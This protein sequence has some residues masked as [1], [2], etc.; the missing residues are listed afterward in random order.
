[1]TLSLA[2]GLWWLGA[3]YRICISVTHPRTIWRTSFTLSMVASAIAFTIYR[4]RMTL[5]AASGLWNF[6]GLLAHIVVVISSAFLCIYL[7][8]LQM[9]KVSSRRI[10]VY[11]V[12]AVAAITAM[13]ISWLMAPVHDQPR[14]DLLP[15]SGNLAVVVYC[16]IFW[17]CIACISVL[18]ART[19]LARGRTFRREDP[20]RSVSLLLI[21]LAGIATLPVVALWMTSVLL[22]FATGSSPGWINQLGDILFPWPLLAIAVGVLSLLT[23]PYLTALGVAWQRWHELKPL[24]AALI[25]NYPQVHLVIHPS[26]GPLLRLQTKIERAIIEIHDALRVA[27]VDTEHATP[28]IEHLALTDAELRTPRPTEPGKTNPGATMPTTT[29]STATES[30]ATEA[31]TLTAGLEDHE[32]NIKSVLA[33]AR[34]YRHTVGGTS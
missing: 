3:A 10:R 20:A 6:A 28:L 19:C 18:L 33:L 32:A 2:V 27:N 23:V 13:I 30:T 15:L 21:G 29:E 9:E 1:M 7:D 16:L 4:F 31:G 11:A 14:D 17:L 25:Q 5:D 24:W 8:A 22:Q 12:V 34:T 26:G